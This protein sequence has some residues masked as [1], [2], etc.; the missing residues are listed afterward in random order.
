VPINPVNNEEWFSLLAFI[1]NFDTSLNF[2][3]IFH[4]Q[5]DALSNNTESLEG[6]RYNPIIF[7][8]LKL[9]KELY[10]KLTAS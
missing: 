2:H 4:D 5:L 9:I 8:S 6:T 1:T 7:G 10:T 3:D